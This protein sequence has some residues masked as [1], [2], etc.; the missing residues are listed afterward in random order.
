M[1]DYDPTADDDWD[2][3]ARE[4]GLGVLPRTTLTDLRSALKEGL[5]HCCMDTWYV[6]HH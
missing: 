3:R 6:T 2:D 4:A 5:V 1:P